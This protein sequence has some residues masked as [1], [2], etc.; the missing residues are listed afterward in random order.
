MAV[1]SRKTCALAI[2]MLATSMTRTSLELL[3]YK[4]EV[5]ERL[6]VVENKRKLLLLAFQQLEKNGDYARLLNI[7]RDAVETLS[8]D[9]KLELEA[10][11]LRDGFVISGKEMVPEETRSQEHKTALEQLVSKHE[12]KLTSATLLHHLKEAEVLFRLEKWDASIGQARNF[13]EQLLT[14]IACATSKARHETPNLEKPVKVRDYL[15]SC[16]FFDEAERK[17]LVDGVYGYFSEE[18]SH[19]GISEQSTARVCL[20]VLWTFGFYVLEKFEKWPT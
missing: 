18:G 9:R 12:G 5:S 11:L 7:V 3:L 20:S 4:H 8:A 16:G 13:V 19:P 2:E 6:L 1:L 10:A 15:Q 14:D 17:K